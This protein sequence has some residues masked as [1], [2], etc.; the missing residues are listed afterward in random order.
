MDWVATICER[1]DITSETLHLAI[2]CLDHFMDKYSIEDAQLHLIALCCLLIAGCLNFRRTR[3][4][5][6]FDESFLNSVPL[7]NKCNAANCC[8]LKTLK[9]LK[10]VV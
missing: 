5:L 8:V 7:R 2:T 9:V 1:C 4:V 3:N 6:F 10:F